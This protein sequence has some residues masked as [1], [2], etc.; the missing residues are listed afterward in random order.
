MEL[1]GDFIWHDF[2]GTLQ[3]FTNV[4]KGQTALFAY[5][6]TG[7]SRL[8]EWEDRVCGSHD[9]QDGSIV[10]TDK[11]AGINVSVVDVPE[12]FQ[13]GEFNITLCK[14]LE[15]HV[16]MFNWYIVTDF[17]GNCWNVKECIDIRNL[18]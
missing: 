14:G 8:V 17:L 7:L 18:L 11:F 5:L 16:R 6:E 4:S 9:E 10:L 13:S 15:L 2:H 1:Q 12:V 3:F